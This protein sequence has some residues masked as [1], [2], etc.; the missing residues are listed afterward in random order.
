M[1]A[2]QW[3]NTFPCQCYE[4]LDSNSRASAE[5]LCSELL[6]LENNWRLDNQLPRDLLYWM[7]GMTEKER[8]RKKE[9][10]RL[11]SVKVKTNE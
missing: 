8:E 9:S 6:N 7:K 10:E 1:M 5:S 2:Q 4:V 3:K 11:Y